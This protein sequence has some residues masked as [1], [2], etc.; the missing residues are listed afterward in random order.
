VIV[1]SPSRTGLSGRC[2]CWVGS[3]L[4]FCPAAAAADWDGACFC[5]CWTTAG[6]FER[7]RQMTVVLLFNYLMFFFC[8]R[9]LFFLSC[10]PTA[11]PNIAAVRLW[12]DLDC[13]KEQKRKA[14]FDA[15]PLPKQSMPWSSIRSIGRL[16]HRTRT[17]NKNISPHPSGVCVAGRTAR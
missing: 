6:G 5:C 7:R 2:S 12:L 17:N 15:I 3:W 14:E 1:S 13:C 9:L 8:R 16:I 10:K 4:V 11:A